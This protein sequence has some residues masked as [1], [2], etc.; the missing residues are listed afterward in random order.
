M[1]EVSGRDKGMGGCI[2]RLA[3]ASFPT[4]QWCGA[5]NLPECVE[6]MERRF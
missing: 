6:I 2:P 5:S 4:F 1:P 3:C